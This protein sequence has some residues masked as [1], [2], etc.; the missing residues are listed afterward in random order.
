[1]TS[2]I[3]LASVSTSKTYDATPGHLAV[4]LANPPYIAMTL[5]DKV[6]TIM[7]PTPQGPEPQEEATADHSPR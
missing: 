1:M 4:S 6:V 2:K 5:G 3:P 7:V